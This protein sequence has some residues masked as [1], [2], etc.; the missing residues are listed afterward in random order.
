MSHAIHLK[1]R[2]GKVKNVVHDL[3]A[4]IGAIERVTGGYVQKLVI[5]Q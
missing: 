5:N 4:A 2:I 3:N 1:C